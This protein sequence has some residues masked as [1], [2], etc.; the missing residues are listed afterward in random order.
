MRISLPLVV[1]ATNCKKA[2]HGEMIISEEVSCLLWFGLEDGPT[3]RP[4]G[5]YCVS[6]VSCVS[7]YEPGCFR[8]LGQC[9]YVL[10]CAAFALFTLRVY[11][12][13]ANF[14]IMYTMAHVCINL[15]QAYNSLL[16]F[17]NA[18]RA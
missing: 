12:A 14:P 16:F 6:G 5:F 9:S 1:P 17:S 8:W 18:W 15:H 13:A 7:I 4:S 3:F 10:N 11:G 2:E